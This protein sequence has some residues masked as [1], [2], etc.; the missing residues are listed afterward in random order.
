MTV[1]LDT[2][3]LIA[4]ERRD[5]FLRAAL[6]TAELEGT[7][8]LTSAGAL[9]QV[10]RDGARQALLMRVLMGVDVVPLEEADSRR[11]GELLAVSRTSDVVDAHVALLAEA[12]GELWTSDEPDL[13]ALLRAR[14]VEARVV[15][16]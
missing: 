4:V 9:A 7:R 1:V 16:V 6:V 12:D 8:V 14:K 13:R 11:I 15:P 3:A 2:G 5:R 10:W